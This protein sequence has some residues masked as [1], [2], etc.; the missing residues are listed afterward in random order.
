[1]TELTRFIRRHRDTDHWPSDPLPTLFYLRHEP[2]WWL[3]VTAW[4][5]KRMSSCQMPKDRGLI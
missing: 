3:L 4:K 2:W 5:A 1:M